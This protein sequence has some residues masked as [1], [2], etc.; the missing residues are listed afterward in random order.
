MMVNGGDGVDIVNGVVGVDGVIG[1]DGVDFYGI[2]LWIMITL[3]SVITTL[4]TREGNVRGIIVIDC[5]LSTR[6]FTMTFERRTTVKDHLVLCI[7]I[8]R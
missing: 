5:H 2:M 7:D 1:V 4:R 8:V 6:T 3:C